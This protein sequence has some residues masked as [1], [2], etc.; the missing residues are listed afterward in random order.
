MPGD[1]DPTAAAGGRGVDQEKASAFARDLAAEVLALHNDQQ[2][3]V[4]KRNESRTPY[5]VVSLKGGNLTTIR[6]LSKNSPL[7]IL[8]HEYTESD[9]IL[10]YYS[11]SSTAQ[12]GVEGNVLKAMHK[13]HRH[14]GKMVKY[15]AKVNGS[16]Y[17][18]IDGTIVKRLDDI[19]QHPIT[20]IVG[21]NAFFGKD[22]ESAHNF[23]HAAVGTHGNVSVSILQPMYGKAYAFVEPKVEYGWGGKELD[24]IE[25]VVLAHNML[26]KEV[27]RLTPHSVL[28]A[29]WAKAA[30]GMDLGRHS[31][32]FGGS[33]KASDELLANASG[34]FRANNPNATNW[35]ANGHINASKEASA[36]LLATTSD[37]FREK[38]PNAT[39]GQ[40]TGHLTGADN[41]NTFVS[42]TQ[43]SELGQRKPLGKVTRAQQNGRDSSGGWEEDDGGVKTRRCALCGLPN[44]GQGPT[45]Q[46][47]IRRNLCDAKGVW[48]SDQPRKSRSGKRKAPRTKKG[49]VKKAPAKKA[50]DVKIKKKKKVYDSEE[51]FVDESDEE[52]VQYVTKPAAK[53]APVAAPAPPSA[54]AKAKAKAKAAPPP[55]KKKK[56]VYDSEEDFVDE[57]D[58][59]YVQYV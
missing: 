8:V 10:L 32:P 49:S 16:F 56:K 50:T 22:I 58:E 48:R 29:I 25:R 38:N 36:E 47:A 28:G 9:S 12:G 20:F 54:A 35:Q 57:S 42:G 26:T 23:E 31:T 21:N 3:E 44:A 15:I 46:G 53:P 41:L 33:L 2:L 1:N 55:K 6:T 34:D 18:K 30:T 37:D 17:S 4:Q 7:R 52:Y 13:D 14:D 45:C 51:D 27:V 40:V 59:E 11:T 19:N 24:M 39:V 43:P 5:L